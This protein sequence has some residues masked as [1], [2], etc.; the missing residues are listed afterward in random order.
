MM[1][2]Q[3]GSQN[4]EI[5]RLQRTNEQ[6]RLEKEEFLE[7]LDLSSAEDSRSLSLRKG[8]SKD[9]TPKDTPSIELIPENSEKGP[10]VVIISGEESTKLENRLQTLQKQLDDL[11]VSYD[12][13]DVEVQQLKGIITQLKQS[14]TTTNGTLHKCSAS[15]SH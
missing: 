8:G 6:L 12:E 1:E 15:F 2:Q 9:L 10:Q 14:S 3:I 5:R 7:A 4:D 11:Q 13:K